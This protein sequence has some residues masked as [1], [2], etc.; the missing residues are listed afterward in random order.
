MGKSL[1]S[2]WRRWSEGGVWEQLMEVLAEA[3]AVPVP[4]PS[5]FQLPDLRIEESVDPRLLIEDLSVDDHAVASS[6]TIN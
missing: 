5:G 3:E 6:T 1:M 2:R 4:E